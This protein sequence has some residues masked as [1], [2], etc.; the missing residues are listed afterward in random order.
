MGNLLSKIVRKRLK[1]TSFVFIKQFLFLIK[2]HLSNLNYLFSEVKK[3][4]IHFINNENNFPNLKIKINS[5]NYN[6]D[7]YISEIYYY[8]RNSIYSKLSMNI[9]RKIRYY[10]SSYLLYDSFIK[11]N[12][13]RF[14]EKIPPWIAEINDNDYIFLYK[15][16]TGSSFSAN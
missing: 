7:K 10:I 14:E 1:I 2:I 15:I 4:N 5:I 16:S 6:I 3:L 8:I 9:W 11:T 12:Y 13:N